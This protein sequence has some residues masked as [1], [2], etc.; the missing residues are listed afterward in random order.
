MI[1]P[2][3]DIEDLETMIDIFAMVMFHFSDCMTEGKTIKEF[4]IRFK[5]CSS[6]I[7]ISI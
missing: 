5:P 1:S 4:R 7:E 6:L 2:F 3:L